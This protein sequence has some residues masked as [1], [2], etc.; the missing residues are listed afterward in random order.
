MY[1]YVFLYQVVCIQFYV[2][3]VFIS[4]LCCEFEFSFV[5]LYFEVVII[6][7]FGICIYIFG[8]LGIGKIVIVCEVVFYFDV[9]V[10]VD[11]F[12]DFIFVEINGMKIIDFY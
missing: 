2:V 5:Y 6:D 4:L 3:L 1:V 7:G 12:D 9:V 10:C 11:E 8:I